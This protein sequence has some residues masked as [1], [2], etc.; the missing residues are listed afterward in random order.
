[1]KESTYQRTIK[2]V[3]GMS[4]VDRANLVNEIMV[5]YRYNS[6][7]QRVLA[8]HLDAEAWECINN[9][10]VMLEM[11]E[12]AHDFINARRIDQGRAA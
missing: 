12:T 10:T 4:A 5:D 3:R 1:M 9:M 7:E 6:V 11:G 2:M 8:H